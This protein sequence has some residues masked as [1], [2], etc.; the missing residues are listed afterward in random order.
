MPTGDHPQH[1]VI[2]GN[3]QFILDKTFIDHEY[4][5]QKM[6]EGLAGFSVEG[7]AVGR[8]VHFV[9]HTG[10]HCAA[11]ITKVED[12]KFPGVVSLVI[13][14]PGSSSMNA[15]EVSGDQETKAV[16]TWHWPERA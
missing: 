8:V 2:V 11:T 1:P 9:H 4:W 12:Q 10:E 3:I 5:R 13:F 16:G 6:G 15:R 7:L 14:P